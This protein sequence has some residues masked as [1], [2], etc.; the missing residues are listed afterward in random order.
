VGVGVGVGGAPPG[1]PPP[2]PPMPGSSVPAAPPPPPPP[3]P[4]GGG[5]GGGVGALLGEIMAGR[6]LRKVQTKD[7]SQAVSAGKVL[8]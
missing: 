4:A 1:A 6:G 2:P 8:G 7:R 5:G 3:M